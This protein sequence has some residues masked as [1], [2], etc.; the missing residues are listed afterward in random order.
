MGLNSTGN[1]DYF[2]YFCSTSGNSILRSLTGLITPSFSKKRPLGV[3]Y[4]ISFVLTS[5]NFFEFGGK[6]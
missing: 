6:H 5:M 3:T 4:K 2:D 1:F